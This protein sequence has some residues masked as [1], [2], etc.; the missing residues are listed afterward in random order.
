MRKLYPVMALAIFLHACSMSGSIP[1]VNTPVP[2]STATMTATATQTLTATRTPPATATPTIMRF[3]TRDPQL[4][5]ET[6]VPIPLFIGMDT[7][8]PFAPPAAFRP[9]AGFAL[10]LVADNKIYWGSCKPNK[11]TITARVEDSEEVISVVIFTQVKSAKEED[12]T[13]WTSG[14]AM[15]NHQDGTFSYVMIGS[16][17]EGHNHYKNSWVRFQLVATNIEGEEVGRTQIY[18]EAIALSPCMCYE[19]L[20]GCP[21]VTPRAAP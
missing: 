13:P 4:P 5:T 14:N 15:F 10:V 9:G 17:V 1:F 20:K 8:T 3:P 18:T 2:T 11:T 7:A 19:P 6:V 21:I 12:S 16:E